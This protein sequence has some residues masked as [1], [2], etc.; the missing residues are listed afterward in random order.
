M[1]VEVLHSKCAAMTELDAKAPY[2]TSGFSISCLFWCPWAVKSF[3]FVICWRLY[4]FAPSLKSCTCANKRWFEMSSNKTDNSWHQTH[5]LADGITD[6]SN[7]HWTSAVSS[8]WSCFPYAQGIVGLWTAV[9]KQRV[10]VVPLMTSPVRFCLSLSPLR[11][12]YF[13][14][15]FCFVQSEP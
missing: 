11:L 8:L 13:V 14:V 4:P 3:H 12:P 9:G 6:V 1:P 15:S 10:I 5:Q 7:V 2:H